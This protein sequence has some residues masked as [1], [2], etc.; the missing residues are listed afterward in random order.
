MRFPTHHGVWPLTNHNPT[1]IVYPNDNPASSDAPSDAQGRPGGRGWWYMPRGRMRAPLHFMGEQECCAIVLCT[2]PANCGLD[3]LQD[4]RHSV[5]FNV[6][7]F[8]QQLQKHLFEAHTHQYP[9]V[10][11]HNDLSTQQKRILRMKTKSSIMFHSLNLNPMALSMQL[12]PLFPSIVNA[13]KEAHPNGNLFLSERAGAPF[14]GFQQRMLSRFNAG[15][16]FT[17]KSL[18]GYTFILT[19]DALYTRITTAF[20]YD[21]FARAHGGARAVFGWAASSGASANGAAVSSGVNMLLAKWTR[22]RVAPP[23]VLAQPLAPAPALFTAM[24]LFN[25]SAFRSTLYKSLY[26][27]I[28]QAGLFLLGDSDNQSLTEGQFFTL[29]LPFVVSGLKAGAGAVFE[30]DGLPLRHPVDLNEVYM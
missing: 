17:H 23:K 4:R 26:S 6:G 27:Q 24:Q 5:D 14:R 21:P 22:E 15:P 13:T 7:R 18:G 30:L 1:T 28:D 8:L 9:I 2:P 25:L 16:L 20:P 10:M 12:R 19:F 29:V 3:C 11:F